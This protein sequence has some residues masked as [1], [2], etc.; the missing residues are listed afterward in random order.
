MSG[1]ATKT[2]FFTS[3]VRGTNARILDTR[4]TTPNFRAIEKWAVIIGGGLNHRFS[5]GDLIMLKDN[6]IDACG[7]IVPAIKQARK[8][9]AENNLDLKIEAETRNLDE[10]R[11]ALEC[12][13]D[14]IMFDNMTVQVMSQAVQLVAG[15]CQTEASG[16]IT[17][18]N[19]RQV[20][21]TG[22]DFISIGALTHSFRSLDMSLKLIG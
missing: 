8:Y 13:P 1:I 15:K 3:L 17:E 18:S 10:V 5:L 2:S 4:K 14:I 6:H 16:G 20:A 11:Q 7:G 22:V 12:T 19:V 21:E 9:L